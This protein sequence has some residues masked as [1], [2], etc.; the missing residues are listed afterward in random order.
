MV[1][2]GELEALYSQGLSGDQK[3]SGV[4]VRRGGGDC[5]CVGGQMWKQWALTWMLGSLFTAG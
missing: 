3:R 2:G 1:G 5:L 4:C